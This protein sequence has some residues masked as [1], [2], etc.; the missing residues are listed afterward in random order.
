MVNPTLSQ[1]TPRIL[2]IIQARMASSRLPG[3]VLMDIGGQP[4]LARVV[5]RARRAK[6]LNQV[7]VATTRDHCDDPLT[8]FCISRRYPSFRGSQFDVLDRFYQTAQVYGGDVIVRLTADCP[9]IDPD[10]IDETVHAFF[11]NKIV[12]TKKSPTTPKT[13]A[14][15]NFRMENAFDFAA[16]R[17]PPPW[18]RTY[19][20][21]LDVEVCSFAALERAW[22][23]ADQPHHREHVMPYFYETQGRF[24][25][26]ILEHIPDLGSY[27]WTVD[28]AEDLELIR[29]I[30]KRFDNR[31]DFSWRDVLV[32]F[33]KEPQL[34]QI[35]AH[36]QHKSMKDIDLHN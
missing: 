2:A 28:T 8:D 31:D 23:E 18:K 3:K 33:E 15:E 20:I 22:K 29:E 30:Y 24:Q 17:L 34:A 10:V 35:N 7:V 25:T 16:N 1:A 21:G 32:L 19:P 5:E 4:M 12:G 6:L 14:S 11:W 9:L 26:H 27:R 13:P 36:V